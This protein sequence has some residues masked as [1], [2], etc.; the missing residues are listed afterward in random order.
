MKYCSNCGTEL[1]EGSAFCTNCGAAQSQMDYAPQVVDSTYPEPVYQ[2]QE[3]VEAVPEEPTGKAKIFGLVS[4]ICGIAS[5]ALCCSGP[6]PGIAAIIFSKLAQNAT[7]AGVEN[8]KA[9]LGMTLGIIG[10][11]LGV[12]ACIASF[13]IGLIGG[14]TNYCS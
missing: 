10:T 2:H 4:F 5:V 1:P 11:A 12:V 9:K 13:F 14:L 6:V 3:P 7:A 8:K